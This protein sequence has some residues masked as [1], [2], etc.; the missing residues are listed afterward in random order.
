[1]Y[2]KKIQ[3]LGLEVVTR[4]WDSSFQGFRS[5]IKV[6]WC[7][8][9]FEGNSAIR[10]RALSFL[11]SAWV[12]QS[13]FSDQITRSLLKSSSGYGGEKKTTGQNF[14]KTER[15]LQVHN[16]FIACND[17]K[18]L[19]LASSNSGRLQSC[20]QNCFLWCPFSKDLTKNNHV[21][22][23]SKLNQQNSTIVRTAE[24]HLYLL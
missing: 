24:I 19:P 17:L 18:I 20:S 13:I 14:R 5:G 3:H 8:L 10:A 7:Y 4:G 16:I 1:M 2:V 22:V 15:A 11:L 6:W 21:T 12:I 9:E 23:F